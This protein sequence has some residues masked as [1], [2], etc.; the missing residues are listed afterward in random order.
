MAAE[1]G[2]F[3]GEEAGEAQDASLGY[4]INT[5]VAGWFQALFQRLLET[6]DDALSSSFGVSFSRVACVALLQEDGF[7]CRDLW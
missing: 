5:W 6:V 1:R 7:L 3:G 2:G 4:S